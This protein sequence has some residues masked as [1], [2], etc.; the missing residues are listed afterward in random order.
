MSMSIEIGQP[1]GPWRTTVIAWRTKLIFPETRHLSRE[2]NR[3]DFIV[4]RARIGEKQHYSVSEPFE[5]QSGQVTG[6]KDT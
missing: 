2:K 5:T 1:G 3:A 4:C 6:T